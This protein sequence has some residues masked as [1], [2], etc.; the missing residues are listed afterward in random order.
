MG[1]EWVQSPF[2]LPVQ[3]RVN[4]GILNQWQCLLAFT[5]HFSAVLPYSEKEEKGAAPCS[6]VEGTRIGE[7]SHT[8]G[9]SGCTQVLL[10]NL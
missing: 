6:C 1:S 9:L 10:E 7:N 2:L 4:I 3:R 5:L 8:V